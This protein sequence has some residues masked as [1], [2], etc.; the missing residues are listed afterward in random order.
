MCNIPEH[1]AKSLMVNVKVSWHVD[2]QQKVHPFEQRPVNFLKQLECGNR[3]K[4]NTLRDYTEFI[5]NYLKAL[6]TN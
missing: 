5:L 1:F 2:L 6:F 3:K 4:Q